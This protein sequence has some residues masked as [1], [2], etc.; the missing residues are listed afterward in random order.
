MA[1]RVALIT[2]PLDASGGIGRLMSYALAKLGPD[3]VDVS[4]LDTRG[5]GRRPILSILPLTRAWIALVLAGLRRRVDVAHINVS[6]HGSSIRKPVMLWTCRALRIPVIL[7]LHASE[8]ESFFAALPQLAKTFLRRTFAAA[9]TVL[10]LGSHYRSYVCDELGVPTTNVSVLLNGCPGPQVAPAPPARGSAP[11]RMLFLG[12]L[13]ERK[14]LPELLEALADA[15]L[16]IEP[17]LVTIAGDGNIARYREQASGLGLNGRVHF[18]GWV[19][20][21][22]TRR[23]LLESDLLLLPSHAEGLP[24]SVIEAFAHGVPVV[25]TPVGAIPD[26][27]EHGVNG[28]LVMPGDTVQLTDALLTLLKDE[29]LRLRLGLN[30]R[31]AWEERL[32]VVSYAR[33]LASCWHRVSAHTLIDAQLANA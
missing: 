4:V 20:T 33:D 18:T 28:L 26:I 30:A 23:L 1:T 24:M 16:G 8:Y 11:L 32:N 14:G 9:D 6:S 12:R 27:V 2:P 13:G 29:S 17:W 21:A 25:T 7:H 15:R 31:R 10:V 5:H 3:E 22:E 19:D